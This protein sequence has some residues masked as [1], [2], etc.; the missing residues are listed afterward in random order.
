[1]DS[2]ENPTRKPFFY[3]LG[4]DP[5]YVTLTSGHPDTDYHLSGYLTQVPEVTFSAKVYDLGSPFGIEGGRV[6]K[7]TTCHDGYEI[8]NYSRGWDETPETMIDRAYLR[9]LLRGFAEDHVGRE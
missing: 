6:S 3:D 9:E 1:M 4:Y 8:L 2:E 7:L 5:R